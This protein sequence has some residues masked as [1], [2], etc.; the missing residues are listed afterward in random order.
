MNPTGI[1][2]TLDFASK[3]DAAAFLSGGQSQPEPQ[4]GPA[5]DWS[6][7]PP[8]TEGETLAAYIERILP[9]WPTGPDDAKMPGSMVSASGSWVPAP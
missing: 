7:A 4:P 9:F 1:H 8:P 5:F 2:V 3:E 6:A